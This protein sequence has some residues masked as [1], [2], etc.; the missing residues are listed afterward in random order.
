MHVTCLSLPWGE[1]GLISWAECQSALCSHALTCWWDELN[2]G[3]LGPWVGRWE[4]SSSWYCAGTQ[5]Y[6]SPSFLQEHMKP[7]DFWG[8]L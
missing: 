7:L 1:M 2:T 6:A 4:S 3:P 5:V 8:Q